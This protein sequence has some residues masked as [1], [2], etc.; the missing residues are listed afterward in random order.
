MLE[1]LAEMQKRLEE[2]KR[3]SDTLLIMIMLKNVKESE[4]RC[5]PRGNLLTV[6]VPYCRLGE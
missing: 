6:W 5:L 3:V 1:R 4:M 2:R